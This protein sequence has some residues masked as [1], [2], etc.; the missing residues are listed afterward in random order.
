MK[1]SKKARCGLRAL[2]DLAVHIQECPVPLVEIAKRQEMSTVN[3]RCF[4]APD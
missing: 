3:P 4:P 2:V 1:V